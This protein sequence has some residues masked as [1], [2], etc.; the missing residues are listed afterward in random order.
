MN[1]HKITI[2][3]LLAIV[4]TSCSED[5]LEKTSPGNLAADNFFK[6]EEHAVWGTNAIY[7]HLRAWE[8]HVFSF[9]GM[10]DIISDDA[11]K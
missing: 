1:F 10:T 2:I 6:T 11:D 9:I 4:F 5:F 3:L 8:V 7:E